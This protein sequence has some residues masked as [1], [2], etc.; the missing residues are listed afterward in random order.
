MAAVRP[1]KGFPFDCVP[2]ISTRWQCQRGLSDVWAVKDRK[3]ERTVS[4]GKEVLGIRI[5][6]PATSTHSTSKV[7]NVGGGTSASNFTA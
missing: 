2:I 1:Q 6:G 4:K 7:G 5:I 3:G